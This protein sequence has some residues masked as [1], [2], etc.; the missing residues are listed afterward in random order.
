[1][2]LHAPIALY[3][4]QLSEPCTLI[5]ARFDFFQSFPENIQFQFQGFDTSRQIHLGQNAVTT[6]VNAGISGSP[7]S[8]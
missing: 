5:Q 4:K 8:R 2:R 7:Q 6:G 1:M 3:I